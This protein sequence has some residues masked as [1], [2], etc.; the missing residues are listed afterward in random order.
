MIALVQATVLIVGLDEK[1]RVLRELPI[2]VLA[3]RFGREA[4]RSL[5]N[6][7]VN[8]VVCK[9]DLDDMEDGEFLRRL[10]LVKPDI[11]TIA[12]IR[13]GDTRQEVAARSLGVSAVLSEGSPDNLLRETIANILCLRTEDFV[14]ATKPS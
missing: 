4:A 14:Y 12:L 11:P 6:K 3:M 5:K 9:W 8:S 1:K 2:E 7:K 10:R 13:A